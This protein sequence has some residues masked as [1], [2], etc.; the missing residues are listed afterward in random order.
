MP[1][2]KAV[3]DTNVKVSVAFANQ[4]LA[5]ELENM[6][7]SQFMHFFGLGRNPTKL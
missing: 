5:K 2:L 3:I 4:G 1:A 6:I 7:K